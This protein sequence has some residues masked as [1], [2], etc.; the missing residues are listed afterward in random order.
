MSSAVIDW[1]NNIGLAKVQPSLLNFYCVKY[2]PAIY[3]NEIFSEVDE[4]PGITVLDKDNFGEDEYDIK[5]ED[6][7]DKYY[8]TRDGMD[9]DMDQ[10]EQQY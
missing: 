8:I 10:N 7:R 3:H 6:S 2:N 5:H 9:E 4:V 1:L